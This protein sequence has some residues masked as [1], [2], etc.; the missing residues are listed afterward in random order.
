MSP[1]LPL[2]A[3]VD[4]STK[5]TTPALESNWVTEPAKFQGSVIGFTVPVDL[6]T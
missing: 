1:A 6:V 5:V 3:K 4:S 2:M